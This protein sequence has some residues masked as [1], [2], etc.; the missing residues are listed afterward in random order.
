VR[1]AGGEVAS[2]AQIAAIE[3]ALEQMHREFEHEKQPLPGDR[4]FHLRSSKRPATARWSR[5]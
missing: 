1:G 5:S 4:L 3:E 2:K